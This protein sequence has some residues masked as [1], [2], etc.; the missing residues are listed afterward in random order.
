[1]IGGDIGLP[2]VKFELRSQK[3]T[4]ERWLGLC[5]PELCFLPD[6]FISYL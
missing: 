5:Y 2:A 6:H 1:M 4:F 3:I